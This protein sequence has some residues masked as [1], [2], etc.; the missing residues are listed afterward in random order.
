MN[1][2]QPV[3]TAKPLSRAVEVLARWWTQAT[4]AQ[5]FVLVRASINGDKD[6]P[7][8]N[9]LKIAIYLA[10]IEAGEVSEG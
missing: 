1:G 9:T 4:Q 10:E 5:R 2:Q 6:A 8:Y 7:P 3:R